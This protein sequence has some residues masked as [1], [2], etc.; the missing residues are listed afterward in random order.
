M[1]QIFLTN[2]CTSAKDPTTLV[3]SS[4]C[5]S[6]WRYMTTANFYRTKIT[7]KD[8]VSTLSTGENQNKHQQTLRIRKWRCISFKGKYWMTYLATYSVI[9]QQ[10]VVVVSVMRGMFKTYTN[11]RLIWQ[12]NNNRQYVTFLIWYCVQRKCKQKLIYRSN[13]NNVRATWRREMAILP[14]FIVFNILVVQCKQRF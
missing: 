13:N 8:V 3:L 12:Q 1:A 6:S 9:W 10:Q 5:G 7:C 11:S 4:N 2:T 14:I